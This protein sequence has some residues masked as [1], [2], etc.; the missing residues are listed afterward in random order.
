ME[1]D[2]PPR[3]QLKEERVHAATLSP[4]P[5]VLTLLPEDGKLQPCMYHWSLPLLCSL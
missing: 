1:T 3:Q 5:N 4:I 2:E